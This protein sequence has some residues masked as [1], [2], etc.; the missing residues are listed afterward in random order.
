MIKYSLQCA[1]GH[2]FEA[3]FSNSAAYDAQAKAGQ[4]VCPACGTTDVRKALMAPAVRSSRSREAVARPGPAAEGP[5]GEAIE[6]M[7]K[8]REH[9]TRNAE[10]VGPRF[11]DEA[12]KIH[13]EEAEQRGI[14]GEASEREV[15]L[16]REE[17]V[18]FYPM[19]VLP[20]DHN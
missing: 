19:P 13:N 14:Y 10:Y 6:L 11:A 4:I 15:K 1:E 2:Q 12:M 7:R 9:V 3:W 20:E 17:G 8:L 18:E 5:A 16:L